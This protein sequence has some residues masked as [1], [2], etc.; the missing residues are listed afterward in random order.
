[1]GW[2]PW[3]NLPPI[4]TGVGGP[5]VKISLVKPVWGGGPADAACAQGGASGLSG[6]L[7]SFPGYC[8]TRARAQTHAYI[9][10]RAFTYTRAR[11]H[12]R[13]YTY[14]HAHVHAHAHAHT[15]GQSVDLRERERKRERERARCL[16][17][18]GVGQPPGQTR[19][20]P[21]RPGQ[22]FPGQTTGGQRWSNLGQTS[23]TWSNPPL[24][25]PWSNRQWSNAPLGQTANGLLLPLGQTASGPQV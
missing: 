12:V 1:M 17:S 24:V 13:A 22:I 25:S 9:L 11:I 5:L 20:T 19:S 18:P 10:P 3:S 23:S 7:P 15:N 8:R 16:Y 4:Q 21:V 6:F 14:A 2:T